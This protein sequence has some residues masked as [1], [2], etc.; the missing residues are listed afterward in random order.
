M[1]GAEASGS[2]ASRSRSR[3]RPGFAV[4]AAATLVASVLIVGSGAA[5]SAGTASVDQRTRTIAYLV[6]QCGRGSTLALRLATRSSTAATR[7]LVS[8]AQAGCAADE[9]RLLGIP[10]GDLD[11]VPEDALAA[12]DDW[13]RGLGMLS[14]VVA[15]RKPPT[16]AQAR[17]SLTRA[18]SWSIRVLE[19]IDEL[20][21]RHGMTPLGS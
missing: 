2:C 12:L 6:K 4:L 14:D 21:L 8:Q 9:R 3:R 10:A 15:R 17:Q 11:F 1:K 20:R 7:E 19:E 5:A 18:T 16:L 13:Q